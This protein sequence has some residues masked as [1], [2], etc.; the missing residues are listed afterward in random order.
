VA[1]TGEVDRLLADQI[2]YYEDRAPDYED[3]WYRRGRHDLGAEFNAAWFEE[4]AVVEAFVD[5]AATSGSVLEI[6]CGSGLWTRRLAPRAARY[7]ALDASPAMLELN[8]ARIGDA[9]VEFVLADA[10]RWQPG[11]GDRFDLIFIGFFLSHVPPELFAGW[12]TRMAAW[13]AHGGRVCF[14]DD[15]AGPNRPAAGD[16]PEAGPGYA[17]HRRLGGSRRYT[18]VKVYYEAAE[19]AD[20]LGWLGWDA[21]VRSTGVHMLV[22]AAVP[23][24]G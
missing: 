7:V 11:H 9:P 18:I 2:R 13:L 23:H 20:M 1:T 3:L 16:R 19:L 12:W 6:G 15:V 21:D 4:T 8:Q 5:A 14:V 24:D 17:H 22:G 10:F